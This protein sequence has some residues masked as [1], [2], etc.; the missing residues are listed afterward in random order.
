MYVYVCMWEWNACLRL[1]AAAFA[2]TSVAIVIDAAIATITIRRGTAAAV[3]ECN[4]SFGVQVVTTSFVERVI[5]QVH[6]GWVDIA[7]VWVLVWY[8]AEAC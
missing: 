5:G 7:I 3:E 1:L 8:S 4:L 2:D 6:E